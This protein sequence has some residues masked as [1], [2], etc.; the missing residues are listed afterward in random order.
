MEEI[1]I[2]QTET[3]DDIS[4]VKSTINNLE[5]LQDV[6]DDIDNLLDK[7]EGK[8]V[9]ELKNQL[10]KEKK[11]VKSSTDMFNEFVSTIRLTMDS[12]KK[13]DKILTK[14]IGASKK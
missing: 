3:E 10:Q 7:S 1:K 11:L 4:V 8:F 14:S 5:E 2:V 6:I 12:F 9:N 13:Q